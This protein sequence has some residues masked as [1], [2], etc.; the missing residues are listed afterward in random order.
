MHYEHKKSPVYVV[1]DI[2]F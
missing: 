2:V 1:M